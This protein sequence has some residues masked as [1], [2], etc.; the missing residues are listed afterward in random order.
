MRIFTIFI[1]LFIN[2]YIY[3]ESV[4]H[5]ISGKN[6][7]IPIPK[8]FY[9]IPEN[10]SSRYNYINS[11]IPSDSRL[12]EFFISENDRDILISGNNSTFQK[13]IYITVVKKTEKYLVSQ[14]VF[15]YLKKTISDK[16]SQ[17]KI[18]DKSFYSEVIKKYHSLTNDKSFEI[19]NFEPTYLGLINNHPK[20]ITFSA[21]MNTK[22]IIN[23]EEINNLSITSASTILANSKVINIYITSKV[24]DSNDIIWAINQSNE[25][26]MEILRLNNK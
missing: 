17:Q 5:N 3:C 25:I 21:L 9:K 14:E 22:F 13:Y 12:L 24:K 26:A 8:Y 10:I 7:I 1:L 19:E 16:L 2:S 23:N 15:D 18:I 4:T 6:I 20:Y 11:M